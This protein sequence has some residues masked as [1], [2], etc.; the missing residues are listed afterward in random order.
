MWSMVVYIHRGTEGG[1]RIGCAN[2]TM[3]GV[4]SERADDER[5]GGEHVG[6]YDLSK[7]PPLPTRRSQ[8]V[9][10]TRSLTS[11]NERPRAPHNSFLLH[12][13]GPSRLSVSCILAVH[14]LLLSSS[15][16]G[17]RAYIVELLLSFIVSSLGHRARVWEPVLIISTSSWSVCLL[18]FLHSVG[19]SIQTIYQTVD[20]WSVCWPYWFEP[21]ETIVVINQW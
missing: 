16:F 18:N 1:E 9:A 11:S 15:S 3:S 17:H 19:E 21:M 5:H 20:L 13:R 14:Q 4:M 2:D 6:S 7:K 12:V 8:V 10:K